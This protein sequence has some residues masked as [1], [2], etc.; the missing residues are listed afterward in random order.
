MAKVFIA[1]IS[2]ELRER[3]EP[4][5]NSL[6]APLD[7]PEIRL[8]RACAHLLLELARQLPAKNAELTVLSST[9]FALTVLQFA[10]RLST[11]A[12]VP[13]D[14]DQDS[15][16]R[17]LRE[18]GAMLTGDWRAAIDRLATDFYATV[19]PVSHLEFKSLPRSA[20]LQDIRLG[21]GLRRTFQQLAAKTLID[22]I[23]LLLATLEDPQAG[24]A[25]RIT[26]FQ[27]DTFAEALHTFAAPRGGRLPRM[28]R[29]A[30]PE[31]LTLGV[32]D[33]ALAL[34]TILR[35]AGGEFN[36]AL[37]GPWG[38]G[39]TTLVSVLQPLLEDPAAYQAKVPP[40]PG[41]T[42]AYL[43]YA[44]V[45]HNA[46]K[47]RSPPE[48]WIYLYKTLVDGAL[49]ATSWLDRW[50]IA[51]RA[52]IER[53]GP[54]PIAVALAIPGLIAI[55]IAAKAQLVAQLAS[56]IGFSLLI[57]VIAV[58]V[59]AS[60]RVQM[61]FL[62]H[63]R[64]VAGEEKL[65]MLALVGDDVRCLIRA[66]TRPA[67]PT[68]RQDKKS[69]AKPRLHPVILP[70]LVI[71]LLS[72]IWAFGLVRATTPVSEDSLITWVL[73]FLPVSWEEA[74]RSYLQSLG[75]N[76]LHAAEW[77]IWFLWSA[78]AVAT[79]T[80][81]YLSI[82]QRPDRV[83]LVIDDLD[84]CGP[85]EMLAVI[86]GV[87]LLLDDPQV[88]SRLQV[89]M[90]VDEQVLNHAIGFKYETMIKERR[91]NIAEV[92]AK[93]LAR[94]EV[95]AEQK[96]KLFAC[97][98]RI[99]QLN[100]S[101]VMQLVEKLA[102]VENEMLK[103][104]RRR[105]EQETVRQSRVE[106]DRLRQ[107]TDRSTAYPATDPA[108]ALRIPDEVAA[109]QG[110]EQAPTSLPLRPTRPPFDQDDVRF[111]DAEIQELQRYVPDFF[112]D[113]NRKPSPR[114]IRA[115]LFKVQLCR[116]LLQLRFPRRPA[117][118]HSVQAILSAFKAASNPQTEGADEKEVVTIAR[119]VI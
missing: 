76:K 2:Q 93:E 30:A 70:L 6:L 54:W 92:S 107:P 61:L 83:L 79:L 89:L 102:G 62:K 19:P 5:L 24:V 99:S 96:E 33:Y 55:P 84:R 109:P 115:L 91:R 1:G 12:E 67:Q 34:A 63:M 59:G 13:R 7:V 10:Q 49:L 57:Y 14:A 50:L 35:T 65:G 114:A 29:D 75:V 81:G 32:T 53:R 85:A 8:S 42:Y 36:F 90:L 80:V 4:L 58:M 97:H 21:P 3:I 106:A 60:A 82:G 9:S 116:L 18:W 118:Y 88:N 48:A 15:E 45:T 73:G 100:I 39:K 31:E 47:Y 72:A 113:S 104:R 94:A 98:L 66:W 64:L 11:Q 69:N 20:D 43:K 16:L 111:S 119:Q 95:I 26:Q 28:V 117:G 74:A 52:S 78:L 87:R 86:E 110:V 41:N 105:E 23:T 56:V 40:H 22:S 17:R 108:D 68:T 77:I 38:S 37:Y 103:A 25:K 51:I 44:V 46:W 112:A 101:D 71:L 27:L